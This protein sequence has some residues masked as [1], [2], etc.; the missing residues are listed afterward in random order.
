MLPPDGSNPERGVPKE[1]GPRRGYGALES[2]LFQRAERDAEIGSAT[3]CAFSS[4]RRGIVRSFQS[5]RRPLGR[6]MD[7]VRDAA[8]D[9]VWAPTRRRTSEP[10]GGSRLAAREGPIRLEGGG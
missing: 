1:P 9:A 2:R 10:S 6:A 5:R 3:S 8:A 4:R 7:V